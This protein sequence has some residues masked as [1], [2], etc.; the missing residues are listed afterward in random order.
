MNFWKIFT[1]MDGLLSV[2]CYRLLLDGN[3]LWIANQFGITQFYWNNPQ[4]MD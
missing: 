4:R 1:P 2:P 3:Y